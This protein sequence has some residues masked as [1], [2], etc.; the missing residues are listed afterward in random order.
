MSFVVNGRHLLHTAGEDSFLLPLVVQP[1]LTLASGSHD[2]EICIS[3]WTPE[4]QIQVIASRRVHL[5]PIAG[6]S[7]SPA[8]G[9]IYSVGSQDGSGY[10]TTIDGNELFIERFAAFDEKKLNCIAIDE[11]RIAVG[12]EDG[13]VYIAGIDIQSIEESHPVIISNRK[14]LLGLCWAKNYLIGAFSDGNLLVWPVANQSVPGDPVYSLDTKAKISSVANFSFE[15]DTLM[16][17][18]RVNG[19]ILLECIIDDE[20]K[21]IRIVDHWRAPGAD[22]FCFSLSIYGP[23][24]ILLSNSRELSV[25]DCVSREG[26]SNADMS[27]DFKSNKVT[28]L[29][30]IDANNAIFLNQDG[31]LSSINLQLVAD[32]QESKISDLEIVS[33]DQASDSK[34]TVKKIKKQR[35][36]TGELLCEESAEKKSV[37][38]KSNKSASPLHLKNMEIDEDSHTNEFEDYDVDDDDSKSSMQDPAESS[39]EVANFTPTNIIIPFQPCS[40]DFKNGTRYLCWNQTG[41]ITVRKDEGYCVVQVEFH[42]INFNRPVRFIDESGTRLV[43]SVGT[44]GAVFGQ[45]GSDSCS[46]HYIPLDREWAKIP[47]WDILLDSGESI[48][49]IAVSTSVAVVATSCGFLRTITPSQIQGAVVSY[50]GSY[51]AMCA[52]QNGGL[53]FMLYTH[54][55]AIDFAVYQVV[56]GIDLELLR[57]GPFKSCLKKELINWIGFSKDDS[58]LGVFDS[59]NELM[60]VCNAI[61][62]L[63]WRPLCLKPVVGDSRGEFV[64]PVA[65]GR[66]SVDS[67]ICSDKYKGP[68]SVMPVPTP[69][70]VPFQSPLMILGGDA[71]VQM[72]EPIVRTRL[73][74]NSIESRVSENATKTLLFSKAD[75]TVLKKEKISSDRLNLQLIQ[76]AINVDHPVRVLE[77]CKLLRL[78]KSWNLAVEIA[79]QCK[80]NNLADKIESEKNQFKYVIQTIEEPTIALHRVKQYSS[81]RFHSEHKI[82]LNQQS[83]GHTIGG[84][85]GS[86]GNNPKRLAESIMHDQDNVHS[87]DMMNI[88]ESNELSPAGN[89]TVKI[90]EDNEEKQKIAHQV[91][92]D[93]P[94]SRKSITLATPKDQTSK[95]T[96]DLFNLL[97]VQSDDL[98]IQ[99]NESSL[100]PKTTAPS[101]PKHQTMLTSFFKK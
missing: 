29:V 64:W 48:V 98:K 55:E 78:E 2:G 15:C 34:A 69:V 32:N 73:Y 13:S 72:L 83:I 30:F 100:N 75:Q 42:N 66:D 6:M 1:S 4:L 22:S 74:D 11:N 18:C 97:R 45:I 96:V 25:I 71:I 84:M 93:N 41:I 70:P 88:E 5:G 82:D 85:C 76:A 68:D 92:D 46:I 28:S 20:F 94:F 14:G 16:L 79:R 54:N 36:L 47:A 21:S 91:F 23:K 95:K 17:C 9:A 27:E 77:L 35:T 89:S 7:V 87:S 60:Y 99:E 51:V 67:V 10:K 59:K 50:P 65:F 101:A 39:Y 52:S 8:A 33:P 62:G 44:A 58:T 12:T 40:T 19:L 56:D 31:Y 86:E 53:I 3:K 43:G 49:G 63:T 80:Y 37:Q 57:Y 24:Q 81:K 61:K 26:I 38:K 90:S